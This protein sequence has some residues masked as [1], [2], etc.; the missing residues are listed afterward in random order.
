MLF[1]K[2][3]GRWALGGVWE[4]MFLIG[5]PG[6][7]WQATAVIAGIVLGTY[8]AAFWLALV[9]WTARDIRQRTSSPVAQVAAPLMVLFLFLPGV[10]LYLMLRPR[11]TQAQLYART[12]E[13]EALRLEL[14][15]QVG[16]PA[17]GRA[18]KDDYLVCPACAAQLKQP[19]TR[20]SKP[21]ANAWVI[22]PYCGIERQRRRKD[23]RAAKTEE[24]AAEGTESVPGAAATAPAPAGNGRERKLEPEVLPLGPAGA[25]AST[26]VHAVNGAGK[27]IPLPARLPPKNGKGKA[28]HVP[29]AAS[30]RQGD[31]EKAPTSPQ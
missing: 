15:R 9:F 12:L 1:A 10:W 6:G 26:P 23:D 18:V 29:A 3:R 13:E 28:E 21:L 16:C 24:P 5:W 27:P 22:C 25:S 14:D 2:Q 17:C 30:Q 4:T 11:Y 8:L 20:C 7:S 19:C 31:T